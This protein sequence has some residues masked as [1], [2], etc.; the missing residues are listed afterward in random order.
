VRGTSAMRRH[1]H[2]PLELAAA[3]DG[4]PPARIVLAEDASLEPLAHLYVANDGGP[5]RTLIGSAH[6]H[7]YEIIPSCRTGGWQPVDSEGEHMLAMDSEIEFRF[8][9]YRT[10]AFRLRMVLDGVL[11]EWICDH[12]RQT[13][14]GTIEAIEVKP[15]PDAIDAA[16]KRKLFRA[17]VIL[18]RLGW[19]VSIRYGEEIRGSRPRQDNRSFVSD[20]GDIIPDPDA[21]AAFDRMM[22]SCR[23]TTY[24]LLADELSSSQFQGRAV[25]HSLM[26]AG[27]VEFD[28]DSVLHRG[29][30]IILHPPRSF[31]SKIRF[32]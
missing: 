24:G 32:A 29:T 28:I 27:R 4:A 16:Y 2:P 5:I 26:V 1:P 17:A 6:R 21:V 20:D 31:I 23:S 12:L 15:H 22:A 13:T 8:P 14:C 19:R 10:Q 9:D 11:D 3:A 18:G 7:W 25:V 30:P